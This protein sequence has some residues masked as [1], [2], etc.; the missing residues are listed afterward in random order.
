MKKSVSII[1]FIFSLFMLISSKWF[2]WD[3]I[4]NKNMLIRGVIFLIAD[5]ICISL[6]VGSVL[7]LIYT[8]KSK[9]LNT[10]SVCLLLLCMIWT[11][12]LANSYINIKSDF[13]L[14]KHN[15]EKIVDMIN[16][17]EIDNYRMGEFLYK[18]PIRSASQTNTISYYKNG[19]QNTVVF[20]VSRGMFGSVIIYNSEDTDINQT[21]TGLNI[22]KSGK[23]EKNWYYAVVR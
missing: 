9:L 3:I 8:H 20:W 10:L 13:I 7:W 12:L 2:I 4:Y 11:F 5:V 19:S 22:I 6:S 14:N 1:V 18:T 21:D 15:R 16:S 23:L 17:S